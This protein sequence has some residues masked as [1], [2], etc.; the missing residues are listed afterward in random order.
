MSELAEAEP[1]EQVTISRAD[2][3]TL[4]S[5]AT[6]YIGAFGENEMMTLPEKFR[7]QMVEE[8]VE[9]HGRRY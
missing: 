6:L 5:V 9:K 1:D 7:L 3:D 2:L 4:L 8:V